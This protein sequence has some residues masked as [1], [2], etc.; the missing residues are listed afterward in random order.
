ME[1][2]DKN[3]LEGLDRVKLLSAPK[4]GKELRKQLVEMRE[5]RAMRLLESHEKDMKLIVHTIGQAIDVLSKLSLI[6]DDKK[7][8]YLLDEI[9]NSKKHLFFGL[10]LINDIYKS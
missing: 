5:K 4:D 7:L 10:H 6:V 9:K 8:I 3:R 2:Q 1:K